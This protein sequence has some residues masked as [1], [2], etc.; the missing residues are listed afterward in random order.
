MTLLDIRH[1]SKRF[2]TAGRDVTALDDLSL[3][4]A[5]GETLGLA[6]ASG[7]G[8]ST[9]ARV[10]MRLVAPDEGEIRFDGED[11]LALSGAQLRRR[12]AGLQM[13]FQDIAGAFNPHASVADVLDDPLRIHRIAPR[14][15]RPERIAALLERVS[16]SPSLA[17]RPVRDLSGGQRQ[18]VAIARAIASE[19]KLIVL[20]EAVSALD[21]SI[22]AKILELLV[23][24][25][26]E[27]GIAY[28]FVSHDLA[29]LRAVSH[30]IAIMER[31]R[32]VESG[33]ADAVITHP[34]AVATKALIAAVPKLVRTDVRETTQ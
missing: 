15:E 19:P 20:D 8:K 34:Q 10:L 4:I 24:L 26:E 29:V 5:P 31:G 7:S 22:R 33:P 25:Q 23:E 17:S 30:H 9:L 18:R 13:V 32:I 2:V 21:V 28:L 14:R 6:G 16:L 12:R 3:T 11:W 1:L 27:R